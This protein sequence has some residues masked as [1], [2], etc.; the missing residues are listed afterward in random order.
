MVGVARRTQ[1][2]IRCTQRLRVGRRA[3]PYIR[4]FRTG[5]SVAIVVVVMSE[6]SQARVIAGRVDKAYQ[7]TL[8]WI[9]RVAMVDGGFWNVRVAADVPG[10][11]L[12]M[13]PCRD[14][15]RFLLD[16]NN[17]VVRIDPLP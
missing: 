16:S 3:R 9:I 15:F 4:Q 6:P 17:R 12:A 1:S 8:S 13:K 14:V 11:S 5:T 7:D 10:S 2:L